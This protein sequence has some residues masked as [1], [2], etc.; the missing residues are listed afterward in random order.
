MKGTGLISSIQQIFQGRFCA[1][2]R[3]VFIG[4]GGV[5]VE[6]VREVVAFCEEEVLLA[7]KGRKLS[8]QGRGLSLKEIAGETLS[9]VGEIGAV[10]L[11]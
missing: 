11:L 10:K 4:D 3:I 1:P 7:L 2:F 8:V 9:I 5:Y 6:G